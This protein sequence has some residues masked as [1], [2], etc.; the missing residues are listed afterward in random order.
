MR[1]K[2]RQW[3]LPPCPDYNSS[4]ASHFPFSNTHRS[5]LHFESSHQEGAELWVVWPSYSPWHHDPSGGGRSREPSRGELHACR[6]QPLGS[7]DPDRVMA[8]SSHPLSTTSDPTTTNIF[9]R[10]VEESFMV[11]TPKAQKPHSKGKV[12]AAAQMLGVTTTTSPRTAGD[13]W[14][15]G[16]AQSV[17]EAAGPG[18]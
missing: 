8:R 1:I 14:G 15:P 11:S 7:G 17:L 9:L 6:V 18:A 4:S 2:H 5:I 12:P 10:R 16:V 3:D 13:G